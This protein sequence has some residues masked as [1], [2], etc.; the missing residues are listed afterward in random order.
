MG[1]RLQNFR[2][3]D[4][5][6]LLLVTLLVAGGTII[7]GSANGWVYDSE[8]FSLDHLMVRQLLGYG[9]GLAAI[10]VIMVCD[11]RFIKWMAVPAYVVVLFLLVLVLRIGVGADE[12]DDVRR[13][14]EIGGQS[15]QPSELGKI[16]LTLTLAW[17]LDKY[18]EYN[19]KFLYWVIAGGI[20]AVPLLL[21]FK[22]PDLSTS[23]VIVAIFISV[24]FAAQI[25]WKYV[26]IAA[27]VLIPAVALIF[28][29][30]LSETPHI[31]NEYQA[32]RI[33]AWLHPEDYA[34]TT[35][36]Q[37]LQAKYAIGSG[38]LRGVGL[39]HNS[40]VVPIATT[41][42][43]FGIIGEELGFIGASLFIILL[44]ALTFRILWISTQTKNLFYKLICVGMAAMIGFQSSIHMGVN[45]S[46]LPNTGL[47]LPFVSY[48]LSS[49][50]T[51]MIGI[52]LVLRIRAEI[53]K[54][55]GGSSYEY[56][57][58]R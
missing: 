15:L 39:F 36:Y 29:D 25:S 7:I 6:L 23:I 17:Y 16:A 28:W 38:G 46:I 5:F 53:K 40:G 24:M 22:E 44:M 4:G 56:R 41:D 2:Y 3:I 10:A 37:S 34:L 51:N 45:T 52:G 8:H 12:G 50:T 11:L 35:A 58:N 43:I 30:A 27:A 20:A 1:K 26:G 55:Q 33:L 19:K 14:L 31:L 21:I 49:L 13:W 32:S 54:P 42:F 47:P 57:L 48:G 9:L 18:Q